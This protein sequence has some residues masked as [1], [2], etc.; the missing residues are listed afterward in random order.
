MHRGRTLLC[1]LAAVAALTTFG[2]PAAAELRVGPA[3]DLNVASVAVDSEEMAGI[4]TSSL[5]RYGAGLRLGLDLGRGFSLQATP[6]YLG[7]G[8]SFDFPPGVEDVD[9]ATARYGFL[10]RAKGRTESVDGTDD[11][12]DIKDMTK[13][14][15]VGVT[16][17]GGIE[18]DLGKKTHAFVE[19]VYGLGLTNI[20]D[21]PD[22]PDG[23]WKHRGVQIR[24][25]VTFSLGR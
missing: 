13:G 16:L 4:D 10:A 11:T 12:E 21:D 8:V 24:A 15:D 20:L 3:L 5:V 2:R 7:K 14:L 9:R 25:G 17:G 18:L 6:M 1:A 19:G 23:V 22:D